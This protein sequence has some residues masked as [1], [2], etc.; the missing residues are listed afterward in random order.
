MSTSATPAGEADHQKEGVGTEGS[1]H[2]ITV[3]ANPSISVAPVGVSASA[4]GG[5]SG[6]GGSS[7]ISL[8]AT[9]VGH[10]PGSLVPRSP[11]TAQQTAPIWTN[12]FS[13]SPGGLHFPE[14]TASTEKLTVTD[15]LNFTAASL[16]NSNSLQRKSG[17]KG[18]DRM[19]FQ[20]M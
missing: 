6:S 10:I 17:N 20:R 12:S 2:D 14:G 4:E 5:A 16:K 18:R 11:Q 13:S 8:Q 15:G 9:G 1:E 19:A 7:R 3:G